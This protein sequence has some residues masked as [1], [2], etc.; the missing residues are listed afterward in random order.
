MNHGLWRFSS[1]KETCM[2]YLFVLWRLHCAYNNSRFGRT[3]YNTLLTHLYVTHCLSF[4][5][6]DNCIVLLRF[7]VSGHLFDSFKLVLHD[8][9]IS[10][11]V[12][13]W[14]HKTYLTCHFL[15]KS[16]C[17][18]RKVG[19]LECALRTS[20]LPVSKIVQLDFVTLPTVV[21]FFLFFIL[22]LLVY[23]TE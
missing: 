14:A 4:F 11:R 3:L 9:I 18:A 20:I 1:C 16:Q 15:L 6:V 19:N 22:L 8:R 13:V 17:Q 7:M 10:L 2:L 23:K 21:C 12:E 5:F